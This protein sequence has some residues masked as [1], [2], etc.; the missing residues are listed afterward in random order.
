M[1]IL[2]ELHIAGFNITRYLY[3]SIVFKDQFFLCMIFSMKTHMTEVRAVR[4][5]ILHS[6][7]LAERDMSVNNIIQKLVNYKY[8][9][10]NIA[11]SVVIT[12]NDPNNISVEYIQNIVN[13]SQLQESNLAHL[14]Q[15][16]RNIHIN[17]L[18]CT[19]KHLSALQKISE[20][21]EEEFALVLEDDVLFTE[22]VCEDLDKLFSNLSQDNHLVFL[23]LPGDDGPSRDNIVPIDKSAPLMVPLTESYI[24]TKETAKKMVA[25]FFPI[26]FVTNLQLNF[27]LTKSCVDC[28]RSKMN[29]FVNGSKYGLFISSQTTNNMLVFNREYMVLNEMLNKDEFTI[30]EQKQIQN[31]IDNATVA[32][33]PDFMYLIA[34]YKT[35]LKDYK[36]SQVVYEKA[37]NTL[38]G[39]KGIVNHESSLLKDFIRLHKHLQE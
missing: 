6:K 10:A 23:G 32:N 35:K 14:N 37:Y 22:T 13:Y 24:V 15:Y 19:L 5:Y 26:K 38:L 8:K 36:G 18:S 2:T 11:G 17:Q 33:H 29:L 21:Q 20:Q 31:I 7:D 4:L 34:K 30:D 25:N 16:I 12:D 27:V 39:N 9:N 1:T 3:L 28:F